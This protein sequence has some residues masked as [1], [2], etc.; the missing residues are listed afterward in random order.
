M[1]NNEFILSNNDNEDAQTRGFFSNQKSNALK[2]SFLSKELFVCPACEES[3]RKEELLSGSGRLIA[4][5]LTEELHRS[6]E[7][8]AK[9][10]ELYPLAYNAVVCPKCWF[11][12][13]MEDFSALPHEKKDAAFYESDNRK[14]EAND[15]FPHVDFYE[16]RN[17]A[18]GIVSQYLVMRCYDYYNAEISPTAKQGIAALRTSWLLDHMNE[19]EP[20]Q[21][22]DWLSLLFKRKARFFYNRALSSETDGKET[23]SG[24]KIFGPD[25]DKNYGYEG[26]L[27]ICGLLEF[28]YGDQR[29]GEQRKESIAETKRTLAKMFGLGKSSKSKPGPLL[30]KSRG[31]YDLIAKELNEFDE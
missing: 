31:L 27:Y 4:G 8:S 11:A 20:G 6:Y 25:L 19:K 16:P 23:L 1:G 12:S 14:E 28:K 17:L 7:K 22:W 10:G 29:D 18:A 2:V 13:S 15:I 21:H 3:F 26:F 24:L 9:Y 5:P 30:E